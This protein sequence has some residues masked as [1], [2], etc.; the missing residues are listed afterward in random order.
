M[1]AFLLSLTAFIL[2]SSPVKAQRYT[3]IGL[4]MNMTGETVD[5]VLVANHFQHSTKNTWDWEGNLS[6]YG[7]HVTAFVGFMPHLLASS[8]SLQIGDLDNRSAPVFQTVLSLLTSRY[9]PPTFRNT[10]ALSV[11]IWGDSCITSH[12][13]CL[14]LYGL[15]HIASIEYYWF[16]SPDEARRV[17]PDLLAISEK[18]ANPF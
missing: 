6:G 8:I 15:P 10:D 18:R 1:R 4:Q 2:L 5:S 9:G 11:Y 14:L 16:N 17:H 12:N 13:D 3:F 7:Y